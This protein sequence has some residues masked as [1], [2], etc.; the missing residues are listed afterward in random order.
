MDVSRV[1]PEEALVDSETV[2]PGDISAEIDES[3][4]KTDYGRED[5]VLVSIRIRPSENPSAWDITTAT[6]PKTIKLQQQYAKS[7]ATAPQDF[8]FDEILT[9]SENKPVYNAVARSHVCAAMDGYNAV[10]FAYGQT[11]SGKT[12]T[13]SGD[14]DQ[15]GI[16]PRAMKDVFAYIRRTPNREYLLRC[17][18]LEIYNEAIHDLL[19]PP[20]SSVSQPVQIQGSGANVVLTPLREEVVT[21]LKGVH[22]VLQRGEGNR[23]TASTDWNERSSRSHSVFRLVIES[24]ASRGHDGANSRAVGERKSGEDE[25]LVLAVGHDPSGGHVFGTNTSK[26]SKDRMGIGSF[27]AP[28]PLHLREDID[29]HKIALVV[30]M[31]FGNVPSFVSLG[32][33]GDLE[34]QQL[35]DGLQEE[36]FDG[37]MVAS[38]LIQSGL[39]FLIS[40]RV[41]TRGGCWC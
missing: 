27:L 20:S 12:F 15:P 1:D 29:L 11:A 10:I 5:K 21:S 37:R 16:I 22:E 28:E 24:V 41:N 3:L 17:S 8:R 26:L 40:I 4:L 39:V 34:L 18:Y 35:G 38:P 23:R 14:E 9:G 13:L 19:A 36:G 33:G 7:A 25:D 32:F 6:K 30:V 31:R 2:E